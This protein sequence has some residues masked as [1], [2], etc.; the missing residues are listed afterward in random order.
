MGGETFSDNKDLVDVTVGRGCAKFGGDE[1]INC[2][3]LKTFKFN[4]PKKVKA[5]YKIV[6]KGK[7]YRIYKYAGKKRQSLIRNKVVRIGKKYYYADKKGYT[8]NKVKAVKVGKSIYLATDMD[9]HTNK[10]VKVGSRKYKT[11]KDGK[12]SGSGEKKYYYA[13]KKHYY[14]VWTYLYP[15]LFP[16]H[17]KSLIKILKRKY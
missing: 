8:V 10:T 13:D 7:K 5:S 3:K 15:K 17:F 14:T 16:D 12:V 4:C 1:F 2:D 11:G 6:K 9:M